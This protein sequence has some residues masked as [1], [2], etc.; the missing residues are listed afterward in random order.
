MRL[1]P[2]LLIALLSG[3]SSAP[4]STLSEEQ[5]MEITENYQGLQENYRERLQKNPNDHLAGVKLAQTYFKAG[6]LEASSYYLDQI[7][8]AQCSE[9]EGCWLT[10]AEIAYASDDFDNAKYY[11]DYS[12]AVQKDVYAVKNL[13]GIIVATEGDFELAKRYFFEAR[14][15]F[16]D[17]NAIRNNL[18]MT[19]MLEGKYADA[20]E[21]LMVLYTQGKADDTV[22]ANLIVSL[23]RSNQEHVVK[24]M[25]L[26]EMDET[27]ALLTFAQLKDD[28]H[29]WPEEQVTLNNTREEI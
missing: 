29:N 13:Y 10:K 7:P 11:I 28:L 22:R 21:R 4:K 26:R 25:L 23:M 27:E 16:N 2:L 12:L 20:A 15:G 1:I 14:L 17:E 19:E 6:D 5:R 18:A 9:V 3:C 8:D 24:Q